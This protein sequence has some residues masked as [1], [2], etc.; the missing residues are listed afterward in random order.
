VEATIKDLP[1]GASR[2]NISRSERKKS[3]NTLQGKVRAVAKMDSLEAASWIVSLNFYLVFVDYPMSWCLGMSQR[4]D[5]LISN[6]GTLDK[7]DSS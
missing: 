1:D 7:A 6:I 2:Q 5:T 3:D 4:V